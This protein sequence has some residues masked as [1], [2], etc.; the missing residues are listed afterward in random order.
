MSRTPDPFTITK[1]NDSK[2]YLLTLDI[3]CGLPRSVC[4]EWRRRSFKNL[5]DGLA[6]Y[7]NPM[8]KKQAK[9]A[10][11]ALIF[12]LKKRLEENRALLIRIGDITV[13]AWLVKFTDIETSPRTGI[14]M[15]KNRPPSPATTNKYKNY[16]DVHIK[17]DPITELKMTELEETDITDFIHR[18]AC[19]KKRDGTFL[20]GTRTHAGIIIF[21]RM[22]F[23]NYQKKFP[24]WF[25]PFAGLEP[26][27]LNNGTPSALTEEEFLKFFF[28]AY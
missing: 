6:Q 26:P 8:D 15:A 18:L 17:K 1:R 23:K 25:N 27:I 4:K 13:G 7:R 11:Y 19:H 24:R 12:Y 9:T 3:A 21:L 20:G 22:A 5:P 28:L 14:N 2:T 16:Y 10:A